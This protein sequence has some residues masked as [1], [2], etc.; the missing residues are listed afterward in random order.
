M[1]SITRAQQFANEGSLDWA[2]VFAAI[3]QAEALERIAYSL[4]RSYS[5]PDPTNNPRI[6]GA[7]TDDLPLPY[8]KP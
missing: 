4:E 5:H 3:A 7:S 8:H 6:T 1:D 2:A